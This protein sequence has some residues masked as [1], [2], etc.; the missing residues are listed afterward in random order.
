M[1]AE[2]LTDGFG[3]IFSNFYR[4]EVSCFWTNFKIL[5]I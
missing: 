2:D 5:L 4:F 1:E 3:S